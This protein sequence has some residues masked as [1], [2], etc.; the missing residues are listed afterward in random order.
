MS[1]V[2]ES[3]LTL[4]DLTSSPKIQVSAGTIIGKTSTYCPALTL[5]RELG[6]TLAG[7]ALVSPAVIV[8][9]TIFNSDQT[10]VVTPASVV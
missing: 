10:V 1:V 9:V 2:P 6:T 5:T 8:S 7:I 4:V 3:A